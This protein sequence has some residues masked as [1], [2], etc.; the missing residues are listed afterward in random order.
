MAKKF[1]QDDVMAAVQKL[2]N[3]GAKVELTDKKGNQ[4]RIIHIKRGEFG[5]KKLAV[6]DF[7]KNHH[8]FH[9]IYS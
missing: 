5:L 2:E 1:K 6:I 8:K 4:S 7:L 9:V 3:W